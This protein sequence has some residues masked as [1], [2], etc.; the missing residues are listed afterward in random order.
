MDD[1]FIVCEFVVME[2]MCLDTR[3]LLILSRLL[4]LCIGRKFV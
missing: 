1:V 3:D 2:V 4:G